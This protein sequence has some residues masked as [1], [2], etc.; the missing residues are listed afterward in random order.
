MID[1]SKENTYSTIPETCA[2][3]TANRIHEVPL[4]NGILQKK[5]LQSRAESPISGLRAPRDD[6]QKTREAIVNKFR[7]LTVKN[8]RNIFLRLYQK[9]YFD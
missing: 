1:L 6:I 5:Y 8:V 3:F 2:K 7:T 4:L 9:Y